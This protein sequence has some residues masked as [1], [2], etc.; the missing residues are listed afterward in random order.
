[1]LALEAAVRAAGAAQSAGSA[2]PSSLVAP[3]RQHRAYMAR[4][5]RDECAAPAGSAGARAGYA[6]A[7]E[8]RLHRHM[9]NRPGAA[10]DP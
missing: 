9:R 6:W 3:A 4:S 1:M 7:V 2:A 10:Q 8:A 5:Y